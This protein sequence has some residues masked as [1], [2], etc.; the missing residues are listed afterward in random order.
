MGED[1]VGVVS[2]NP[3]LLLGGRDGSAIAFSG[4]IPVLVTS[5]NGLIKKDDYIVLSATESGRGAKLIEKEGKAVGRALS[6]DNGSGKVLMLVEN[7]YVKPAA[8][9]KNALRK[10]LAE[11][12]TTNLLSEG[13]IGLNDLDLSDAA[14][15]NVK[16]IA[17]S[18]GKWSISEEGRIVAR[19]LCVS[20][21]IGV[22]CINASELRSKQ[23]GVSVDYVVNNGEGNGASGASTSTASSTATTT[24]PTATSSPTIIILSNDVTSNTHIIN[25]TYSD[26][27]ATATDYNGS[28]ITSL[29]I[30]DLSN[31]NM[32]ATGTY[33]I[34]YTVTSAT[35]TLQSSVMRRVTVIE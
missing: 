4:R 11:A 17:S 34:T 30:P 13:N 12:S 15:I 22:V 16:S 5:E 19:E 25:T 31:L 28:D 6:D 8:M 26:P 32:N 23:I 10:A 3:G 35:T 2:S 7:K 14:L 20:D 1:V 27:G 33:N 9:S 29:I 18:N 24:N 21:E